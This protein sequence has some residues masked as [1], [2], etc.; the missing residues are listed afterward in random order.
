MD[1]SLPSWD[2][3]N[4]SWIITE[5][6]KPLVVNLDFKKNNKTVFKSTNFAGYVGMLTGIKPVSS[7]LRAADHKYKSLVVRKIR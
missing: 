7:S 5:K 3:K 4:K 2:M 1:F 6:L